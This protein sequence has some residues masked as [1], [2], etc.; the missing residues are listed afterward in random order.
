MCVQVCGESMEGVTHENAIRILRQT[1]PVI[2]LVIL[3]DEPG[4]DDNTYDIVTADVVKKP[5]H[6]L[7]FSIVT[8]QNGVFISDIVCLPVFFRLSV[9]FIIC[10]Y[11][12]L[13]KHP[14]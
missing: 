14:C 4:T 1:P 12:V 10:L 9:T 13:K 2:R 3:R 5:G 11:T 8:H 6:G 7:G